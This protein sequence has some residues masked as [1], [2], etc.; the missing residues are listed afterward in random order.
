[1]PA[2]QAVFQKDPDHESRFVSLRNEKGGHHRPSELAQDSLEKRSNFSGRKDHSSWSYILYARGTEEAVFKAEC[3]KFV[4]ERNEAGA[5][6]KDLP[7]LHKK[8]SKTLDRLSATIPTRLRSTMLEVDQGIA[9]WLAKEVSELRLDGDILTRNW[10]DQIEQSYRH[11]IHIQH[12]GS[13]ASYPLLLFLFA[14]SP[15]NPLSLLTLP[16]LRQPST[17]SI[18][19]SSACLILQHTLQS[20]TSSSPCRA[21]L[22]C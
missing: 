8:F 7:A 10:H 20:K 18:S 9:S 2:R 22:F 19:P 6:P 4:F 1:M 12:H 3:S 13:V 17:Q 5:H 14:P 15:T 11:G 21:V 16:C